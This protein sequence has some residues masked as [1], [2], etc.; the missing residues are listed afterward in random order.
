MDNKI[1]SQ[2]KN[3]RK[4]ITLKNSKLQFLYRPVISTSQLY[5][6]KAKVRLKG[7]D[8]G[9]QGQGL[10]HWDQGQKFW[11][12]GQKNFILGHV[13]HKVVFCRKF[14][15]NCWRKAHRAT[16]PSFEFIIHCQRD[17]EQRISPSGSHG[18]PLNTTRYVVRNSAP[19]A[20]SNTG[21]PILLPMPSSLPSGSRYALKFSMTISSPARSVGVRILGCQ[22]Q[23]EH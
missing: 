13:I 4:I 17:T 19:S 16:R 22:Q 20:G 6:V 21:P 2:P 23:Q 14:I 10:G 12:Q 3:N 7:K 1:S 15:V 5:T 9:F 8:L 11:S 18:V